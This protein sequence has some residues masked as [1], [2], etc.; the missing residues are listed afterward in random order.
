[1]FTEASDAR[2]GLAVWIFS[3]PTN[4]DGDYEAYIACIRRLDAMM[5]LQDVERPAALQVVDDG[6]PVPGPRWRRDIADA[7]AHIDARAMFGLVSSSTLIRGVVV[8]INWIR[9]PRYTVAC[10]A[11]FDAGVRWVE[12]ARGPA[13]R[14]HA[15]HDEARA[16]ALPAP[17]ARR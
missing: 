6:N 12:S 1:M 8:A 13:P 3:G 7:T 10:H 14:L 11:T 5:S 15:L 17:P 16:R 2:E 9:P 4:T